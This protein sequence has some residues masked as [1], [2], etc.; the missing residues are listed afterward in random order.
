LASSKALIG[1]DI[2]TSGTKLVLLDYSGHQ[3]AFYQ[4]DY[5]IQV[6]KPGWAEQDPELWFRAVINGLRHIQNQANLMNIT[7]SAIGLSGQ[8]HSLICLD[9]KLNVI[10]PAILWADQRSTTIV[11]ELNRQYAKESWGKWIGNPLA[12]GF[13]LPSWLWLQANQQDIAKRTKFLIQPKDWVR[14]KLTGNLATDVSDASAT[15]FFDPHLK[16][17]SPNVLSIAG[18]DD[19]NFAVIHLSSAIGGTLLKSVAKECGMSEEIPVIIGGSDQAMQA[20][21]QGIVAEGDVSIT[22]GSGGQIF[23]PINHAIHDPEL[24]V[25]LFCHS[26]AD[27]WNLE[28]AT[29][30]AGLSLKWLRKI[31]GNRS[32]Y[33]E[34]ADEAQTASAGQDGLFFLPYLNGERTPWMD[35]EACAVFSGMT[36]HH[37]QANLTRAVIEG[38]LFSLR[39]GLECLQFSGIT[40]K[41]LI[42]SG[43]ATR[44]PLWNQLAANIFDLDIHVNNQPEASSRGAAITAFM[45]IEMQNYQDAI[46]L[47]RTKIEDKAIFSPDN[48][49][50]KYQRVYENYKRIYP[51]IK[52][53]KR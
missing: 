44:H 5:D 52:Q 39:Q 40:P 22:I 4:Q 3:R 29:L 51:D 10:R 7:I 16:E 49:A 35:G 2:G 42:A 15:G 23:A 9:Q 13:T 12:A 53:I 45:G 38:V 26:I 25:H 31:F 33:K 30:A 46:E 36:L 28:A 50:E 24:R 14:L 27:V 21:A 18:L 20:V 43:G 41:V 47:L 11:S 32:S 34:M 37:Q 19:G 6:P 48:E 17:W 8:M 1:I